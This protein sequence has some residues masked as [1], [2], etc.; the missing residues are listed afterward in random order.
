MKTLHKKAMSVAA[1]ALLS[2]LACC[3]VFAEEA[4]AEEEKIDIAVPTAL[5]P[6]ETVEPIRNEWYLNKLK[7]VDNDLFV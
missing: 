6:D 3:S 4:A 1:V 5:A 2:G 7:S